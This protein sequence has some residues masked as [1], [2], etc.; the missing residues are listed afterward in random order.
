MEHIDA[1]WIVR[2]LVMLICVGLSYMYVMAPDNP[3]RLLTQNMLLQIMFIYSTDQ[4]LFRRD[5]WADVSHTAEG[6]PTAER[7]YSDNGLTAEG[8]QPDNVRLLEQWMQTE[9]P[10]LN[11]DFQLMDLQAVLMMNRTYLSEFI[12]TT[13]G[14]TFYQLV[15][16]YR[17]EEAKRLM[18]EN[19]H[20]KLAEVRT[21]S[22]F[23]S[24][25]M[26]SRV[27]TRVTGLTPTE[28]SAQL[29]ASV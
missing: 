11:P 28:W 27:F 10:Y 14:C 19:P 5:P 4:I 17:V 2:Y 15:N 23:S 21:R 22:G 20:M 6:G 7:S 26:F 9:K 12:K 29:T 25:V 16:T 13:Y 24:S 3:A 8:G 1:Q 18:Q